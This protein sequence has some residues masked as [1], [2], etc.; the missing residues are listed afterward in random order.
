MSAREV[1]LLLLDREQ[2]RDRLHRLAEAHVVG[3][4]AARADAR[5]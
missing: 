1:L 5:G 4:H 2:E 3:E